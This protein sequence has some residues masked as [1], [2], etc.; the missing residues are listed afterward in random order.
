MNLARFK[1]LN[2]KFSKLPL[3]REVWDTPEYEEYMEAFHNDK[4]CQEWELKRRI[5]AAGINYKNYC[6]NDMAYHLIEDK[7]SKGK[8]EINYDCVITHDK[9]GKTFGLPIH[10]GGSSYIKI[11]HCPWC[12]KQ[13]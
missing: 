7:V 4:Q 5:K 13:L 12:G 8:D 11:S 10:D 1:E 9:K 6:C 3:S 2:K